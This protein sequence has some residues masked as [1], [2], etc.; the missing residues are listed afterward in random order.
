MFVI[1]QIIQICL[2]YNKD[3]LI[4]FIDFKKAYDS[5]Y[6]ES[7]INILNEF[8]FVKIII[9]LIAASFNYNNIKAK[10]GNVSS[11]LKRVTIG[12]RQGNALSPVLFNLVL[13][14]V[15]QEINV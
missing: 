3:V 14:K 15:I 11:Q 5:I 10:I 2:E 12:L 13:E 1:R 6:R 8:K 4:L 9:N 7:L